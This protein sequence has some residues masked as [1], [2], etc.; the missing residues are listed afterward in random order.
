M[1]RKLASVV[2]FWAAALL[3]GCGGSSTP[4]GAFQ[5]GTP[6]GSAPA[7]AV[8]SVT[9]TSNKVSILSDGSE[10]A[11]ITA[12]VR[13]SGNALINGATV[14][15]G[16]NSGGI[17]PP[18]ATTGVDGTATATLVTAGDTTLR[19]ITVTA[20]SGG[21]SGTVAVPVVAAPSAAA[22]GSLALTTSTPTIPSDNSLAATITATV[23]DG[24]NRFMPNIPVT[25]VA[26]SGGLAITQ[27]TTNANGAATATIGAAN[28]KTNRTITVTATA[29]AFSQT[30]NVSVTGTRLSLQGPA[31]L[32]LGQQGTYTVGL[33]DSAD[34]GVNNQAITVS[35][36]NGNTISPA[37]PLTTNASGQATF[38]VTVNSATNDTITASA[39]GLTSNQ[40]VAVNS[41]SFAFTA[42]AENAN[43]NIGPATTPITV[44]WTVAGV[45]Q[46]G[47]VVQFASTRGTLSAPTAVVDGSGN[48]TVNI[49]STSAGVASITATGP[50]G[51]SAQ[52][53]IEFIATTPF[54][55]DIQPNVFTL[56][57]NEQATLTAIVRDAA[58]NLVKNA[59]VNFSLQSDTTGG[60]LSVASAVTDSQGRAQS[61][62]RAG[63]VTSARDGVIVA[64]NVAGVP[65]DTV[66]LTVATK[67]VFISLG[68]G[69]TITEDGSGA[70]YQLPFVV[71]VTDANGN[72]VP[73]VPL[74]MSVLSCLDEDTNR[75]GQLDPGED[76]NL[77]TFLEAGNK[78]LVT[79]NAVT[80]NA[81]GFAN[82]TVLYPQEYAFWLEVALEA[83]T[84]V[85]G[86]EF[87][88]NS[89]FLL[90]GLA[91]DFSNQNSA[92]P[93]PTSPFGVNACGVAN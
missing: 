41:A 48:A 54:S 7:A 49:S 42:P 9:V 12:F 30:I 2:I 74:N 10:S 77:S 73:N 58:N 4:E 90:P 18:T 25:F 13:D 70:Q 93:G 75:N 56:A 43:I 23:R 21:I 38:T 62:Y 5:P 53:L 34:R 72:G 80:T 1:M 20:T 59:T 88:A 33:L 37:S 65:Q 36:A 3:A 64:A 26:S 6:A 44:R 8:A 27:G 35:S 67:A 71:Q 61:V 45:N 51:V 84:S 40:P 19:N 50:G 57:P 83:R 79:P 76:T 68:T 89:T 28:D 81:Q 91:G 92:P 15:F 46:T 24:S 63:T 55:V 29:Q 17:S 87:R 11:T 82:V 66:A 60:T 16:A 14:T 47:Q 52:R 78:A 39:L 85:Q 86:T 31:T 22:V 32:N 69:N